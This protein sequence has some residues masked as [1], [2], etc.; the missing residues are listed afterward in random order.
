MASFVKPNVVGG[1]VCEL[2]L[3]KIAN[4]EL[5]IVFSTHMECI[6]DN[7]WEDVG[8]EVHSGR[9]E[10]V[11]DIM[12]CSPLK[13]TNVSEEHVTSILRVDESANKQNGVNHASS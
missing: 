13:F 1:K 4:I 8:F 3:I 11:C 7:T 12:Q 5:H 6:I 10:K 2:N 9:Y